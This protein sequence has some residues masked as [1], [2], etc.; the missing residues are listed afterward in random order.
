MKTTDQY[1]KVRFYGKDKFLKRL[2]I[3]ETPKL[4]KPSWL[5]FKVSVGNQGFLE[6]KSEI[7]KHLLTTVCK[8]ANCPNIHNCFSHK[9]AT[10]MIMGDICT[11]RCPFC[12]VPFGKPFP[13]DQEEPERIA[14]AVVS[15]NLKHVVL[16]SPDRDD[17]KDGGAEHFSS[18]I[19]A[20]REKSDARIEILAPDFRGKMEKA[21]T[22]LRKTPPD[23]FN[24][25]IETVERLY[26]TV[27]PGGNYQYSLSLLKR[28]KELVTGSITKSGLMVGL[29]ETDDEIQ[30]V[31]DDLLDNG[32]EM[33]TIG[34]YIPPSKEHLP[35]KRYVEPEKFELWK[36]LAIKKGFKNCASGP[37]VRSSYF[38]EKQFSFNI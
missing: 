11:R 37:L 26:K 15:L 2:E 34:Q 12:N 4:K 22:I 38:A 13:L 8:E 16:T 24:H 5:K 36:E 28:W 33:L 19:A 23:I 14:S 17:L 35:I 9:S 18:C 27:K 20:I 3:E 29:G 32:V 30:K 10:F 1:A 25:N 6:T 7:K 31:M 21:L